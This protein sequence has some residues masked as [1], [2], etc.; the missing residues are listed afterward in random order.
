MNSNKKLKGNL[1]QLGKN[2]GMYDTNP[3]ILIESGE[4]TKDGR[5]KDRVFVDPVMALDAMSYLDV[6]YRHAIYL[7]ALENINNKYIGETICDKITNLFNSITTNTQTQNTQSSISTYIVMDDDNK[8]KIGKTCCF[9]KRVIELKNNIGSKTNNTIIPVCLIDGNFES[10]LH[11]KFK[12]KRIKG[13]WFDLTDD[14]IIDA[15]ELTNT[16][17]IK[18]FNNYKKTKQLIKYLDEWYKKKYGEHKF[19]PCT[20]VE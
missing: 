14:E 7:E 11:N 15:L 2:A 1:N 9:D 10:L 6:A 8:Y 18:L 13:E 17:K 12:T 19:E 20:T 4:I 3:I 5:T 16:S